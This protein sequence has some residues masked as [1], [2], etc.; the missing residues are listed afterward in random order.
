MNSTFASNNGSQNYN[1]RKIQD[2]YYLN[3]IGLYNNSLNNFRKINNLYE[4]NYNQKYINTN[5]K[6]EISRNDMIKDDIIKN[7]TLNKLTNFKNKRPI[8]KISSTN[9]YYN[10]TLYNMNNNQ[11]RKI[12]KEI[13]TERSHNKNYKVPINDLSNKYLY[14]N[15]KDDKYNSIENENKN[16]KI[17]KKINNKKSND[18]NKSMDSKIINQNDNSQDKH[19]IND[20]KGK[21]IN[22]SNLNDNFSYTTDKYACFYVNKREKN[23][24][25]KTGNNYQDVKLNLSKYYVNKRINKD[26]KEKEEKEEKTESYNDNLKEKRPKSK[27]SNS[28]TTYFTHKK[29][30]MSK[31]PLRINYTV[32]NLNKEI[33]DKEIVEEI[34]KIGRASCRER[35]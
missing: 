29:K 21:I 13:F 3:N 20:N 15:N 25:I 16:N 34:K 14:S 7:S 2:K 31:Y 32:D 17:I 35:V 11:P 12:N 30:D 1:N 5:Y 4:D 9:Y 6:G 10:N 19:I 26:E 33:L 18:N 27:I 28:K 24:K 22:L 23:I 8:Q